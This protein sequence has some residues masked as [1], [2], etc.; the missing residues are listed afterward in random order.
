M[1]L[2]SFWTFWWCT[3][4][5]IFTVLIGW[6]NL[7]LLLRLRNL[8]SHYLLWGSEEIDKHFFANP[9]VVRLCRLRNTI[10][11]LW[12]S[13]IF[14]TSLSMRLNVLFAIAL[15]TIAIRTHHEV[16]N[17]RNPILKKYL[18]KLL[19]DD[20]IAAS[21][22]WRTQF[23]ISCICEETKKLRRHEYFG[24]QAQHPPLR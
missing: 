18:K 20:K 23:F 16:Q 7:A 22:L 2:S 19:K 11:D 24:C 5:S 21:R 8:V 14:R 10:F 1:Q 15:I 9:Y 12:F 13:V 17:M 3:S 6:F 4:K